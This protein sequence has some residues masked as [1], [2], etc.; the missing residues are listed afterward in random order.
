[1]QAYGETESMTAPGPDLPQ[2]PTYGGLWPAIYAIRGMSTTR[3]VAVAIAHTV[4][5]LPRIEDTATD[6][7][8]N[9]LPV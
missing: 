7:T 9:V 5:S 2:H 4:A 3:K 6:T 1:M 8:H